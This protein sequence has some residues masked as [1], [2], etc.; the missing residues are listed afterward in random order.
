M[1]IFNKIFGK[2]KSKMEKTI[3]KEILDFKI[4]SALFLPIIRNFSDD[5]LFKESILNQPLGKNI[6]S[7]IAK[8]KIQENG[9]TGIDYVLKSHLEIYKID[10][11]EIFNLALSNLGNTHLNIEGLSDGASNDRMINIKSG[12]G[13]AT[14]ILF[15]QNFITQ[16]SNDLNSVN[17][18]IAIINSATLYITTPDSSFEKKFKSIS[19]KID[20]VDT[21]NIKPA[22]YNW[23]DGILELK[24]LYEK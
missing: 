22:L 7:F 13:L 24:E 1:G 20:D 16:L 15:D 5:D 17:L 11:S 9:N 3:S 8:V 6:G 18:S 2:R 21:L 19:K 4:D 14:S 12:I 10:K 23:N